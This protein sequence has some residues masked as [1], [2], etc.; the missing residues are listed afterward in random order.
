MVALQGLFNL[1]ESLPPAGQALRI[2]LALH[3]PDY[4]DPQLTEVMKKI[5]PPEQW[6]GLRLIKKRDFLQRF[7]EAGQRFPG[8]KWPG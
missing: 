1:G 8:G 4:I 3:R 5:A 6:A 2:W 7:A